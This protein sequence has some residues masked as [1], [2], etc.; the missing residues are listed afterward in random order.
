M[1]DVSTR[2]LN[3][4]FS[5]SLSINCVRASWQFFSTTSDRRSWIAAHAQSEHTL[6]VVAPEIPR[7]FCKASKIH[8]TVLVENNRAKANADRLSTCA[9]WV[10]VALYCSHSSR[11]L[12][13]RFQQG[14]LALP[15]SNLCVDTRRCIAGSLESRDESSASHGENRIFTN[16]VTKDYRR[17]IPRS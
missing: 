11:K 12:P 9:N 10:H 5:K 2:Y 7:R 17:F 1:F 8:S 4:R 14:L 6:L 16:Q 13:V 15:H 3:A